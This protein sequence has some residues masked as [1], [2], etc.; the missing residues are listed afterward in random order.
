M[1]KP[2]DMMAFVRRW[3]LGSFK[4]HCFLHTQF[5]SLLASFYQILVYVI[6][7]C[8]LLQFCLYETNFVLLLLQSVFFL[9]G[10]EAHS[11][12]LALGRAITFWDK[13]ASLNPKITPP[14]DL[15]S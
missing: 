3:Q 11:C 2:E 5:Y 10:G 6:S 1:K 7:Q 13:L 15:M 8:F 4:G 9:G 12:W 14:G